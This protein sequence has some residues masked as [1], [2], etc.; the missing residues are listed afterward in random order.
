VAWRDYGSQQPLELGLHYNNEYFTA[1]DIEL[2]A[3]R[4]MFIL[5]Q[6]LVS[7]DSNIGTI[8]ILPL[9]EQQLL[10]KFNDTELPYSRQDTIIDLFEL[11]V[12]TAPDNIAL[13][14]EEQYLS[15]R[16]LNERAN[17]L[18]HYLRGKGVKEDTL[19]PICMGR[20]VEMVVGILGVLK[21]GAAY[22]PIDPEY[23]TE[24]I[25]YMLL[26]TAAKLLL[27]SKES[28]SKLKPEKEIEVINVDADWRYIT[29]YPIHNVLSSIRPTPPCLYYIYLGFYRQP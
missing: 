2:L 8:S 6:F 27:S 11:Q 29:S 16:Q 17:Q 20:S 28:C 15:Y 21:A 18:G 4:I 22:V 5:E 1:E 13:E 7:I 9:Q 24:R 14:F 23:P 19:V 10:N 12:E 3:K 26:D 25:N